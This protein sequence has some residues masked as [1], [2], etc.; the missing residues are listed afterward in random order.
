VLHGLPDNWYTTY[1]AKIRK[2]KAADVKAAAKAVIPSKNMVISIV[3]DMS[4]I[5]GD[6][7]ALGFGDAAM[8]D[9]YGMP[10]AK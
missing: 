2:I 6:I 1:A 9:L 8:H 5:K 10:L 4:K 3:G 7:D